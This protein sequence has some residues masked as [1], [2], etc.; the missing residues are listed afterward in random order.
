MLQ[1]EPKIDNRKQVY[2]FTVMSQYK[3]P[4]FFAEY[5]SLTF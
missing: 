2:I 3:V 4:A 5:D 1:K